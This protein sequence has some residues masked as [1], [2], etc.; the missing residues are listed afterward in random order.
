MPD[1]SSLNTFSETYPILAQIDSPA[2]LREL[3][4]SRLPALADE[5]RAF[6]LDSLSRTGGHLASGLGSVEITIALHYLFNTPDD[7]LVWDV[8][9]QCYPH[10]ILTGRR[11]PMSRLRQ[12]GGLVG[13]SENYR[14][15]IRPFRRRTLQHLDQRRTGNGDR[16]QGH[17]RGSQDRRRSSAT[18]A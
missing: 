9:H 16:G 2:D 8:G 3:D 5:L 17:G 15:R 12:K 6:L 11:E 4:E 18:V 13:F 1:S 10:K 7:R 14:V